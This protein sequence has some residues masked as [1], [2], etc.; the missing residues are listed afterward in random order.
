MNREELRKDINNL[1]LLL[2]CAD[3]WELSEY[4]LK[5]GSDAKQ[6]L[7]SAKRII[8]EIEDKLSNS[9]EGECE[10]KRTS[11]RR[12]QSDRKILTFCH[13]CNQFI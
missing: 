9:G 11:P 12:R 5:C 4:N 10:H 3:P 6:M 1:K 7:D 2:K 13:E 8:I